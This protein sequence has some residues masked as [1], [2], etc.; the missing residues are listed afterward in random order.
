MRK[1]K[2]ILITFIIIIFFIEARWK[3]CYNE[4]ASDQITVKEASVLP[5]DERVR[6][7]FKG[8]VN[9][10]ITGGRY[11]MEIWHQETGSSVKYRYS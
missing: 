10:P 9:K 4:N 2:L 11:I 3:H 5:T 7:Y 8:I 6:I 1:I